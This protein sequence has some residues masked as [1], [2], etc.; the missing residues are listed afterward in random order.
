MPVLENERPKIPIYITRNGDGEVSNNIVTARTK[1]EEKFLPKNL[2]RRK[3][4][5]VYTIFNSSKRTIM[6]NH[7][8][9]RFQKKLQTAVSGTEHTVT[10]DTGKVSHQKNQ[11][12][13]NCISERKKS[14]TEN[15]RQH[16]SKKPSLP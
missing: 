10:T 16:R 8:E 12:G 15:R 4:R 3:I 1:T 9:G 5:L 2:R 11:S 13:S 6:K 14:S 7:L